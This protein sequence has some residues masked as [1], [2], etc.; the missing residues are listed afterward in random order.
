M[1]SAED[2][3]L[4]RVPKDARYGWFSVAVQ[5]FGQLSA[6]SQ[7]LLGATLG[8][9]MSFWSAFWALTLGAVVL[10][11]VSIIIGIAG[12]REGMST[13]LLARWAGFGRYGSA[14]IGLVVA[15]S[16][17]GWFGIQNAVF[18]AGLQQ[19]IG[20]P[21]LWLWSILAGVAVIAIVTYGFLSM[22]WTA[23]VAVPLF[24]ILSGW[25]IVVGLSHHS[26]NHLVAMAPP[27]PHLSLGAGTTL[28]AGGFIVGAVITSD[29]TRFNRRA[30]DVVKQ[31]VLGITLGEYAIG[32]VGVL[33]AH[34]VKSSNVV[35]IVY[36]TSG[37]IGTVILIMATLKI[38]DWNLYSS[39]LGIVNAIDT[40]FGKKVSRMRTTWV[41]GGIGTILAA[42][43]ILQHFEGFL[44][45]LGVAIPPIAGI[46]LT[47]YWLLKRSREELDRSRAADRV[48]DHM[49]TINWPM[50]VSWVGSFLIGYFVH[51]GIQSINALV[52][53]IVLYWVLS[54]LSQRTVSVGK[55]SEESA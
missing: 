23:Y 3:P 36:S 10:E 1:Q 50:V 43:G 13:S 39:T 14:I 55:T 24:L 53:A 4:S 47:D 6:L 31:T 40:L 26:F 7:F 32:L 37:F 18:A 25:A 2:Y 15:I 9:G 51:W 21:P 8:F 30:G 16:L 11:V 48:P 45:I 20:G 46:M 22:G 54:Q 28:V 19:L 27:G 41:I 52:A 33:L 44:T 17:V 35:A 29:M 49:E 38:N 5:R 34:A 12:Q 42:G